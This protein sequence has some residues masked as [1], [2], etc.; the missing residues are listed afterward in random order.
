MLRDRESLIPEA[1][2]KITSTLGHR[3]Y[4]PPSRLCRAMPC[5]PLLTAPTSTL[6]RNSTFP[7][8]HISLI[9]AFC[10][11][12]SP[13]ANIKSTKAS[14]GDEIPLGVAVPIPREE[15]ALHSSGSLLWS[16]FPD[17]QICPMFEREYLDSDKNQAA[18][19]RLKLSSSNLI[20]LMMPF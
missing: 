7:D 5:H 13:S 11:A 9:C 2:P 8:C 6:H 4:L 1:A 19:G 15:A 3:N 20:F 12:P 17:F 10:M 18:T 14:S 16:E